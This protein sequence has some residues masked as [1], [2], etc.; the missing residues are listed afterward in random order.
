MIFDANAES[1][2]NQVQQT[3]ETA[4]TC[5]RTNFYGT[6]QVT[7][8]LLPLLQQSNSARIVNVSS[9]YGQ[10]KVKKLIL[11]QEASS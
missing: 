6:K 8:A 10:L 2:R 1:L 11:S 3:Y 5:L 7:E 4:E 9:I